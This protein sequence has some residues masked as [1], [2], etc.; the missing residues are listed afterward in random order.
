MKKILKI[1]IIIFVI[2]A[3]GVVLNNSTSNNTTDKQT[4]VNNSFPTENDIR[5]MQLTYDNS[6]MYIL[7]SNK[8]INMMNGNEEMNAQS[9]LY[10]CKELTAWAR[11]AQKQSEDM[12]VSPE[13]DNVKIEYAKATGEY[14]TMGD[15]IND[16]VLAVQ[17]GNI[18]D[19]KKMFE[20]GLEH[21]NKAVE[22]Y[23]N[24]YMIVKDYIVI[25]EK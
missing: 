13:L 8:I 6:D 12:S 7:F 23:N 24:Y 22:H 19:G 14:A 3:S 10:N 1:I 4:Y 2:F 11:D 5:W 15:Y 21:Y 16:G 9:L 25:S 18:E 17:R 20:T